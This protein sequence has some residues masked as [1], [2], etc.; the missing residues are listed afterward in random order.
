MFTKSAIVFS[1]KPL[2]IKAILPKGEWEVE[3]GE[4]RIEN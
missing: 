2:Q 4:W 3:S 1:E